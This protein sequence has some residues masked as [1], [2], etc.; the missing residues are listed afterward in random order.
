MKRVFITGSTG[1]IGKTLTDYL[2]KRG[3][4]V[5]A[6]VRPETRL[7]MEW[8]DAVGLRVVSGTLENMEKSTESLAGL[9]FDAFYHL[10]W[11]GVEP[12]LRNEVDVQLTN[13]GYSVACVK[14]AA[15][16]AAHKFIFTGSTMEYLF[17]GE[18]INASTVPSTSNHYGAAKIAAHYLCRQE[19]LKLGVEFIYTAITSVYGPGREDSNVIT[20]T[21]QKLL[22]LERPS[23]TKL[24]Q[25]WD[26]I[27][28]DD[29]TEAL[30]LVGEM[31]K[32]DGFYTIGNGDN[33]PLSDYLLLVRDIIDPSLPLG[34]GEIP[35]VEGK[36]PS[37]CT[38]PTTIQSDTG[39]TP[40]IPFREGIIP[41][42]EYY[43]QK[44]GGR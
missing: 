32:A 34:I 14:A 15:Q 31:G 11:H 27:H 26:Y 19:C 23:V 16:I 29:L 8:S 6:L 12:T 20:Y 28:I 17:A 41:V 3:V 24:E 39:F 30:R 40:K 21:I 44:E 22:N 7:P 2:L 9:G 1:F 4:E 35:Y 38:D 36:L 42:I 10:G 25:R 33:L 43:R 5:Y 18:P 13:V 37:S